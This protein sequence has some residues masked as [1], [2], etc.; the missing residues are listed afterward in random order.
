MVTATDKDG[1][2]SGPVSVVLDVIEPVEIDVKPGSDPNSINVQSNGQISVAVFTT[3]DFDAATIDASTVVFAGAYAIQN[4]L[5]DVDGDGDLDMVLHFW[6]EDTNLREV[7]DLLLAEDLDAD[8]I[9]D[10]TRQVAEVS[11]EGETLDDIIF[12]GIDEVDL[13][14]R[15]KVL[16]DLLDEL[17]AAGAI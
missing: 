13:L 11:L 17:A 14:L 7:Y 1:G 15:G 6:T 4:S 16:R 9:I 5:E 2:T 8:G 3:E 12:Q 10:S